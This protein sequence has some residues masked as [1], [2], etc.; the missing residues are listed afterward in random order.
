M[1]IID[2][3]GKDIAL[4]DPEDP[5]GLRAEA[6][7]ALNTGVIWKYMEPSKTTVGGFNAIVA[8]NYSI[9]GFTFDINYESMKT[10]VTLGKFGPEAFPTEDDFDIRVETKGLNKVVSSLPK[11]LIMSFDAQVLQIAH[12]YTAEGEALLKPILM[13]V[14]CGGRESSS[15]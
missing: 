13:V 6:E 4:P 1:V 9:A 10:C 7:N 12:T 5:I 3:K 8:F 15:Q 11:T 2:K 14:S